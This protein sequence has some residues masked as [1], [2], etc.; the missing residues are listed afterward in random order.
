MLLEAASM[1]RHVSPMATTTTVA[2]AS[3]AEGSQCFPL[4]ASRQPLL[5]FFSSFIWSDVELQPSGVP[6]HALITKIS[7]L[8]RR[9]SMSKLQ[10]QPTGNIRLR[11]RRQIFEKCHTNNLLWEADIAV[12][13]EVPSRPPSAPRV[14]LRSSCCEVYK[15]CHKTSDQR[16]YDT[17]LDCSCLLSGKGK[18]LDSLMLLWEW[19]L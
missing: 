1:V 16:S 13:V 8:H 2:T 11:S 4:E 17:R 15:F 12:V 19:L 3:G 6:H 14:V 9:L 7:L 5:S 18:P 10:V